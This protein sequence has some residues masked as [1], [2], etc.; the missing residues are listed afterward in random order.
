VV[1]DGH[2]GNVGQDLARRVRALADLGVGMGGDGDD[3]EAAGPGLEGHFDRG[4]VQP[5]VGEDEHHVAFLERVALKED[6][7]IAFLALE[8]EELPGPARPDDVRPHEARVVEREKS[9]VAPIA[10]ED[11]QDGDDRVAAAEHIDAALLPYRGSHDLGR[12]PDVFR[13][14]LFDL[15]QDLLDSVEINLS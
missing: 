7:G 2:V 5:A 14:F 13:L 8:P 1:V 6:P 10:R 11:I 4:G 3:P 9:D 12:R 15:R